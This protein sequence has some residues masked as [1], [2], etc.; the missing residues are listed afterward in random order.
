MEK[1]ILCGLD[2]G[3]SQIKLHLPI[4]K[5]FVLNAVKNGE[6]VLKVNELVAEAVKSNDRDFNHVK[7]YLGSGNER[8][9]VPKTCSMF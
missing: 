6:K 5:H 7:P 2:Q 1:F 4:A 3:K 8:Q 9:D